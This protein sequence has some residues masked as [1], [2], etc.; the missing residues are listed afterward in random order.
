MLP[1]RVTR[2]F[3]VGCF[4]QRWFCKKGRS[5]ALGLVPRI[6]VLVWWTES[7]VAMGH[8]LL[9]TY[10]PKD[11]LHKSNC[12]FDRIFEKGLLLC[13]PYW[14]QILNSTIST[15]ILVLG[16]QVCVRIPSKRFC[17][18]IFC[19]S[20]ATILNLWVTIPLKVEGPCYR[21]HLRP[22]ES[23]LHYNS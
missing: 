21:A 13:S 11:I 9:A 23:Y 22:W 4:W 6:V 3:L 8:Q 5:I 14:S 2:T 17:W 10:C 12:F 19:D 7:Q 1:L 16:L 20:T 15:T 18:G